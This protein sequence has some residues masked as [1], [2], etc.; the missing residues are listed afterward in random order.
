MK[1]ASTALAAFCLSLTSFAGDAHARSYA[2]DEK[3]I[4]ALLDRFAAAVNAKD[5]D[6]I[7]KVYVP[8][9]FAFDM[10]PPRQYVG[11]DA[12]RKDW[13]GILAMKT[14]DYTISDVS[15]TTDG[16]LAF[17]HFIGHT[18]GTGPDGKPAELVA[19]V[20]DAYRKIDDRWYIVQ[21]H[22]SLPVDPETGIADFTSKP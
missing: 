8:E 10:V 15:I 9:V 13:E 18:R 21:E 6:E 3:E 7:M 16:T 20:T 1:L 17:S 5:I 4:A 14:I 2:K 11:T 12:Y 22:V 19:R